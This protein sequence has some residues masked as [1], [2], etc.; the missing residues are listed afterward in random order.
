M[1]AVSKRDLGATF[2]SQLAELNYRPNKLP[3][4]FKRINPE[5]TRFR[6]F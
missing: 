4:F 1:P 5:A 3:H 6:G 2:L